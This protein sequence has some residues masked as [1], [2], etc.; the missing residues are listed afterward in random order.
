M[1]STIIRTGVKVFV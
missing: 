1:G